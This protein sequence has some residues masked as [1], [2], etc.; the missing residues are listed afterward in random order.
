MHTLEWST[1][2]LESTPE[3]VERPIECIRFAMLD[4]DIGFADA[5]AP[6]A[7]PP[8]SLACTPTC[9]PFPTRTHSFDFSALLNDSAGR[10]ADIGVVS[11]DQNIFN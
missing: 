5:D 6:P 1:S 4:P 8:F 7:L 3:A 9:P 11:C 10:F 2:S